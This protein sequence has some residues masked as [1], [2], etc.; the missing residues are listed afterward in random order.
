MKALEKT[1]HRAFPRPRYR[2]TSQTNL[3]HAHK[4]TARRG[5]VFSDDRV[6]GQRCCCG[7]TA[8]FFIHLKPE[9]SQVHV[10]S[11]KDLHLIS[12]CSA[13]LFVK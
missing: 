10:L 1:W 12:T 6:R 4:Q 9:T 5:S 11:E 13:H 8:G 7:P 2:V 3:K